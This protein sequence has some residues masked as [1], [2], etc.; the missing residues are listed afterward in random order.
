MNEHDL[1]TGKK[2]K[3]LH[4][5]TRLIIGGAQEN[6]VLSVLGLQEFPEFEITL[7]TGPALG[8]EGSLIENC[9]KKM[10]LKLM[11]ELRRSINPCFDLIALIKLTHFIKKNRFDIV[12]THSSKAGILGRTAAYLAKTPV[13]IHTVHGLPFFKEQNRILN[14][15]YA[16][17]EKLAAKITAKIVCVSETLIRNALESGVAE[18]DKFLTIYSGIDFSSYDIREEQTRELKASLNIPENAFVVGKLAR[19]FHGKGHDY[20]LRAALYLKQKKHNFRILL[21]GDGILKD[22]L[23]R[24]CRQMGIEENCIFAGLIP[25]EQ[26]SLYLSAVNVLAHTSLHE[27]LP[28]AVV[29]AFALGKPA[30]CFDVDGACDAVKDGENGFLI[31]AKDDRLLGEKLDFLAQHP[32]QAA[33]MGEQGRMLAFKKFDKKNMIEALAALYKKEV[34][35]CGL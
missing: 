16:A 19:L 1:K 10:A 22:S 4:I 20:L 23:M 2:F 15:L 6:T 24:K 21:I 13:I 35:K 31:P 29:Q 30:V 8:P 3:V 18:K 27:G 17:A 34:S 9:R 26:I 32:E 12:H 11:P 5:I 33:K 14:L 7:L 28:R 25:P